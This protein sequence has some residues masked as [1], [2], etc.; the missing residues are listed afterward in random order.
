[1]AT[2]LTPEQLEIEKDIAWVYNEMKHLS[3]DHPNLN[4][5]GND[6]IKNILY[7]LNKHSK[8]V[9]EKDGL[10]DYEFIYK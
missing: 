9:P 3:K 6:R 5:G 7:M 8:N 10:K 4:H 2:T 1:M